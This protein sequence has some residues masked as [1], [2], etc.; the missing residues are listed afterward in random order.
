MNGPIESTARHGGAASPP[1]ADGVAPRL[2]KP[3][4][5]RLTSLSLAS[6]VLLAMLAIILRPTPSPI[7]LEQRSIALFDVRGATAAP[8]AVT[9]PA[10]KLQVPLRSEAPSRNAAPTMAKLRTGD[11]DVTL[12]TLQS[13][14]AVG[15]DGCD[16]G[17]MLQATLQSSEA[18]RLNLSAIPSAQRSVANAIMVWNRDWMSFGASPIADSNA[19]I[20]DVVSARI[21]E[22]DPECRLQ[23]QSGP[24]LIVVTNGPITTVLAFGS[25]SW[26]WQDLIEQPSG[27]QQS[28]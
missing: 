16:L 14:V 12:Q 20:R 8:A 5:M 27:D 4:R 26:R 22:A 18:V 2:Y 23:P 24:Q 6:A 15:A 7:R 28:D 21:A 25:G 11:P 9:S 10:K 3:S 19:M 17:A 1:G 13:D